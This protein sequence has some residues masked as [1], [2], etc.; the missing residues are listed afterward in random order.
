MNV[1][2]DKSQKTSTEN[3]RKP[4]HC[5]DNQGTLTAA[6]VHSQQLTRHFGQRSQKLNIQVIS[7]SEA[8]HY[9]IIVQDYL[10]AALETVTEVQQGGNTTYSATKQESNPLPPTHTEN[11]SFISL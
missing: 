6:R 11:I 4:E 8:V 7:L 10:L 5:K 1:T 2:V 3:T 9:R